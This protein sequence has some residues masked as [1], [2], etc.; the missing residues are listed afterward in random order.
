MNNLKIL[1][2]V[3]LLLFSIVQPSESRS[4]LLGD[5]LFKLYQQKLRS[6]FEP[7]CLSSTETVILLKV[8]PLHEGPTITVVSTTRAI[9]EDI[10]YCKQAVWEAYPLPKMFDIC[11]GYCEFSGDIRRGGCPDIDLVSSDAKILK[12]HLIPRSAVQRYPGIIDENDIRRKENILLL[13][14]KNLDNPGLEQFRKDWVAFLV[15]HDSL[16]RSEL[17]KQATDLKNKFSHLFND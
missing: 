13:S 4:K 12:L 7:N 14:A 10:F 15:S 16:T 3:V 5:Q 9:P 11:D 8:N 17:D 1:L 2:G 6:S